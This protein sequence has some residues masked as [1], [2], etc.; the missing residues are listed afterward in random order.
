M[1]K[2]DNVAQFAKDA[3]REAMIEAR[4]LQKE[5]GMS[6]GELC[7]LPTNFNRLRN[8]ERLNALTAEYE[9]IETECRVKLTE[10][11]EAEAKALA[12]SPAC[13]IA[14]LTTANEITTVRKRCE[15]EL[16][17]LQRLE[18]KAGLTVTPSRSFKGLALNA[19]TTLGNEYATAAKAALALVPAP[20]PKPESVEIAVPGLE[21][22]KPAVEQATANDEH[23]AL[24]ERYKSDL[25]SLR[26]LDAK[27]A[28][29]LHHPAPERISTQN[30]RALVERITAVTQAHENAKLEAERVAKCRRHADAQKLRAD[31][32]ALQRAGRAH[33]PFGKWAESRGF[34]AVA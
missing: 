18:R 14:A 19:L 15:R 7:S 11:R 2:L 28:N 1:T 12:D 21:P 30:L 10:K 3:S 9:R 13:V 5:L 27:E 25:A 32:M 34:S 6:E 26:T 8:V 17:N 22:T 20:E 33:Q 24:V 16:A 31:Y 23:C 4:K 29:R